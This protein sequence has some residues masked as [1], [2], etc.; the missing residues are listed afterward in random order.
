[1]KRSIKNN[2]NKAEQNIG[3]RMLEATMQSLIKDVEVK[4]I[5][6]LIKIA[7]I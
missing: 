5:Q 2:L 1:M 6:E 4:L 3:V 7:N